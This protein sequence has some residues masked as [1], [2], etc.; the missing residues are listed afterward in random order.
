MKKPPKPTTVD[1]YI[2]AA[3]Q[4][5]RNKLKQMR[6]LIRQAAPDAD[7]RISYRM[8]Y[9]SY[10]GRLAYFA[11]FKNHIGLYI[12]TPVMEEHSRDLKGYET[13]KATLRLPLDK[14][15]PA[16]LIKKLVKARKRKNEPKKGK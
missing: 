12:P 15:L 6:A 11:V 10:H 3:P 14:R 13:A 5:V 9:Y 4:A 7:E 8:P 2:A 1:A 16:G